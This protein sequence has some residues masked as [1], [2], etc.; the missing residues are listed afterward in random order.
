MC[1]RA[2]A[3]RRP[4]FRR[5]LGVQ[6]EFDLGPNESLYAALRYD[7][8]MRPLSEIIRRTNF[9]GLDLVSGAIEV[10]E[11]EYDTPKA[12]MQSGNKEAALAARRSTFIK[13]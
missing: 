10:S 5:C 4:A 12:I 6:P 9:P 13:T 2:T 8:E 7:D 11:F 3:I 1:W